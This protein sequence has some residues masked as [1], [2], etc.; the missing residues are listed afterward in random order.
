MSTLTSNTRI[1]PQEFLEGEPYSEVKHEFIAGRAY[2]MVGASST[3]NLICVNLSTALR[4]HL[5]R[6]PCQVFAADMKIRIGDDFYY[7]DIMVACE[8][9]DRREYYRELPRLVI[10]VLSPSTTRRD[11]VDKRIAYQSIPSLQE[12]ALMSQDMMT[13]K[14]F[15][16]TETAWDLETYGEG[17]RLHFTSV[18]LDIPIEA[19][20]EDVW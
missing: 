7:P 5:R 11:T 1:T 18:G 6:G 13:V 14:I 3:H 12:Y 17:E 8:P 9:A 15:R 20:Y 16:R 2:A 10:E 19:V 4:N